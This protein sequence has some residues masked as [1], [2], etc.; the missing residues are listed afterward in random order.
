MKYITKKLK[1]DMQS[2]KLL[3]KAMA[4]SIL[5]KKRTISST[6]KNCTINKIHVGNIRC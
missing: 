4:F 5:V 2:D 3:V 1:N 6:V